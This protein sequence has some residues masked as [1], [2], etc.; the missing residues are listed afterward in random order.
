MVVQIGQDPAL[1]RRYMLAQYLLGQQQPVQNYAQGLSNLAHT[2]LAARMINKAE[3]ADEA[4]KKAYQDTIAKALGGQVGTYDSSSAM[5]APTSFM[6]PGGAG[7]PPAGPTVGAAAAMNSTVAPGGAVASPYGNLVRILAGNPDTAPMALEALQKQQLADAQNASELDRQI[8]LATDPRVIAAKKE[9]ATAGR[10]MTSINMPPMETEEA[11]GIGKYNAENFG[12]TQDAGRQA[13]D[14][15]AQ[16]Q[17]LGNLL[18]QA[19]AGR[20]AETATNMAAWADSAANA[21]GL[22]LDDDTR[23]K[24]AAGQG[25]QALSRM[26]A[27][28]LRNPAAGAGMPG[29]M[30]NQDREFLASMVASPT[31]TREGQANVLSTHMAVAK[32]KSE[33]ADMQSDFY[34]QHGTLRGFD[35]VLK[36]YMDKN[37][38]LNYTEQFRQQLMG[39]TASPNIIRYDAQGNRIP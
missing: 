36:G 9:V 25:A 15:F 6:S 34:Y 16:Y 33:V 29:Q 35:K 30:S 37:P 21:L 17:Q 22:K 1:Q 8:R 28:Q 31:Q 10:N 13:R 38:V 32:L 26:M 14:N 7:N 20:G 4:R 39:Q 12:K 2:Y 3:S 24:I 11:K 5:P 19:W 23:Q 27:L 18:N